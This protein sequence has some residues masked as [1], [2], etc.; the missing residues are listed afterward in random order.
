VISD[1]CV[2]G[3]FEAQRLVP[4]RLRILMLSLRL[5]Y[6]YATTH[7]PSL[8]R[9]AYDAIAPFDLWT[10]SVLRGNPLARILLVVEH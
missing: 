8:S 1:L 3:E 5:S 4:L 10:F 7:R 2:F 6:F 9:S